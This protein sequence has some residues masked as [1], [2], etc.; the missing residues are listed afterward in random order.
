MEGA[1]FLAHRS[2]AGEMVRPWLMLGPLYE[3]LSA[4]VDGL[5]LFE[6]S[7]ATVG[8]TTMEDVVAEARTILGA[9]PLEND[10]VTFRGQPLTWGLVRRPEKYL[11]WGTYNISNHLGAAFFTTRVAPDAAGPKRWRLVLRITSRALV[12]V[13]GEVV[14]DL[15]GHPGEAR[16]G[17]YEAH[18]EAPLRAGENVINVAVFRLGR[19]AQVGFR[20][21]CLDAGLAGRVPLQEGVSLDE[22]S[23][24]E[25][26]VAGL[27]LDTDVFGRDRPVAVRLEQAPAGDVLLRLF[28]EGGELL[29][30]V[31]PTIVEQIT[32]G[33]GRRL[34]ETGIVRCQACM[35]ASGSVA[36]CEG[37]T[38]PDGHY[39]I[40]CV[41][42]RGGQPLTSVLFDVHNVTP[43]PRLLGDAHYEQR[44]RLVLE[45]YADNPESRP[46]WQEVARYALGRYDAVDEAS[47]AE[48]CAFI[49]ARKDCADFSIQAILR[50]MVWERTKQRLSPAI[51]ALMKDTILGFKYWVD[52]PGDTVMYMGSENHRL[53]FHVA[54]WMAG[55]LFPTEEFTNSRMRGLYHAT[56]GRTYIAEWFR[57][58]GRFG[59]DEWHSNSYYPVSIAPIVNVYDFA[60]GEDSKLREMAGCI[61]DYMMFNLAQD[62]LD[63]VF[64]T[65]HGRSYGIYVKYPDLEGTSATCWLAWGT[66]SLAK[67]TSGMCPVSMAT[68]TYRAPAILTRMALDN[69]SVMESHERQGYHRGASAEHA[70]LAVYR[71]PDYMISAVQDLR[72][73]EYES[74][75]HVA[76]VT[77]HNRVVLFWSCPQTMGEGSGLRPDY[78]SGHTTLPRVIQHQNVM[79]ITFRLSEFAWM[80]HCF[81]EMARYD[82]VRLNPAASRG[83]PAWAFA[84][85]G[86][87]YVGIWS[88]HGYAVGTLG[89]YAGRELQCTAEENTWL[90]ECGREADWGSFDA[91]VA[92]IGG[93]R[94]GA[95]DGVITYASPSAG[96][97]VTGWDVTPT[98]RGQPVALG[99]YPMVDSNWAYSEYDSGRLS[100]CHGGDAATIYFGQ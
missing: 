9:S 39:Q 67:T 78:W 35:D 82:E 56:K 66:G 22:R 12:A 16:N 36:L 8:V 47:V 25:R 69:T 74:S 45:H 5:T 85:V 53:L 43:A 21:E 7:D 52:E 54:E 33:A 77:L 27:R 41:W 48:T 73:G 89:Q 64:G 92:A 30:E 98:V 50:L 38:I 32:Q 34:P 93:A 95:E 29:R 61:L 26:E 23:R 55:Q 24:V 84:R 6:R 70:N 86:S 65:T 1:E 99:D 87:G 68:S 2:L 17:V 72:K 20:L 40:E 37:L 91:F 83:E 71:T 46:I 59:F 97:F 60:I 75:T 42:L 51:N 4:Q 28:S 76:Q 31:T 58:R 88:Q 94:I 13:N 79:S 15:S 18:F 80:S 3:D 49:A 14:C 10:T 96:A 90:V 63:G 81:F 44:R 100:L 11:S 62:S 19:M 57:Q